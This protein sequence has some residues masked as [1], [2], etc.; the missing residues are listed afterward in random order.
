MNTAEPSNVQM[1]FIGVGLHE[2]TWEVSAET[3]KKCLKSES[4]D[5]SVI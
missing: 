2:I 5:I 4:L 1:T 3:E